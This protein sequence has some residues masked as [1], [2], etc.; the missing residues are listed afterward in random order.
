MGTEG[1]DS[2]SA[3]EKD[4]GPHRSHNQVEGS[5]LQSTGVP[6]GQAGLGQWGPIDPWVVE[7]TVVLIAAVALHYEVWADRA[8]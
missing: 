5:R 6:V 3:G 7:G 8:I 2:S 4:S 1:A